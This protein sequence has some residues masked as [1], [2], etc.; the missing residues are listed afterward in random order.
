[1]L[2][3][4][5]YLSSC[6]EEKVFQRTSSLRNLTVSSLLT[7]LNCI[8]NTAAKEGKELQNAIISQSTDLQEYFR[9]NLWR[10][11]CPTS[12]S[13][14]NFLWDAQS[15]IQQASEYLLK[16]RFYILESLLPRLALL[17]WFFFLLSNQN[18]LIN[19]AVTEL[20]QSWSSGRLYVKFQLSIQLFDA[21]NL[22]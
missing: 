2:K 20:F 9:L 10:C 19:S 18:W 5:D 17:Q 7:T 6:K 21:E 15:H 16:W 8:K 22:V 1:M 13:K 4:L 11:F 3:Q 12:H 14:S